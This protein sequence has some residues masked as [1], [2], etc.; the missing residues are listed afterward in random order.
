[1]SGMS[2]DRH[3]W[4]GQRLEVDAQPIHV[5]TGGPSNPTGAPVVLLPGFVMS[6]RYLEPTAVELARDRLVLAPDLPGTGRS[7]APGAPLSMPELADRV[8]QLMLQTTGAAVVVANSFGC[9][10]AVELALRRPEIVQRLVL[11]SPVLAP[12]L[13]N[14]PLLAARFVAATLRESPRYL[15]IMLT[16]VLR[17]SLRNGRTD[18]R[19]L[20]T[21]PILE[22]AAELT[23]PTVVVRGRRD[24]LV[25]PAF[26]QWLDALI[27]D[28]VLCEIDSTHALPFAAPHA[29][30][31]VVRDLDE[32]RG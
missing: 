18:L 32:L 12:R 16:D 4:A 28:S 7:P 24:P 11:T 1:M 5:G 30:A 15:R 6:A 31:T 9:Q 23:V 20:L 29:V 10:I 13:R 26:A 22:R 17:G 25:L 14:L 3:R 21:E 2:N 27:P 8:H 19:T